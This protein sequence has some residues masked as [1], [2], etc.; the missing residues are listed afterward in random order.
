MK[1]VLV[2]HL[3]RMMLQASPFF[4]LAGPLCLNFNLACNLEIHKVQH[5]YLLCIF[6][7]W[8]SFSWHYCWPLW[9][10]PWSS[11]PGRPDRGNGVEHILVLLKNHVKRK[12]EQVWSIYRVCISLPR[13]GWDDSYYPLTPWKGVP[14][15]HQKLYARWSQV[16][17]KI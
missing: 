1:F 7:W 17:P 9:P 8:S 2:M 11:D 5:T 3:D 14:N 6:L 4:L 15:P 10:W 12:R 13:L 16:P